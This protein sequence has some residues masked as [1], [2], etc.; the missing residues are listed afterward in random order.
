MIF[1]Y[2]YHPLGYYN[3]VMI[4]SGKLKGMFRRLGFPMFLR[5]LGLVLFFLF[6][7]INSVPA[8][9]FNLTYDYSVTSLPNATA[10][11]NAVDF[12]AA[13][14]EDVFTDDVTI[15]VT[16][17]AVSGTSI[18][19]HS[20][21]GVSGPFTY[22]QIRNA[23]SSKSTT[24]D[25]RSAL[26]YLPYSDPSSGGVFY[27]TRAQAKALGLLSPSTYSDGTFSFGAGQSF[28]LDTTYRAMSGRGDFVGIAQHE[29][30]EIM[31][32]TMGA[33]LGYSNPGYTVFDLFRFT[34]SGLRS[35]YPASGAY[36]SIDGGYNQ[37]K[38]FNFPNGNGSDPGDW[39]PGSNDACNNYAYFGVVNEF[40]DLDIR[41]MDVL[42]YKPFELT[43][44][45]IIFPAVASVK[46]GQSVTLS[47]TA[48]SGLPVSYSVYSGTGA[49]IYGNR[50][51]FT[52]AGTV[53]IAAN[54]GGNADFAAAWPV[55][56]TVVVKK[57][58]QS[59]APFS[60]IPE[61]TYGVAPFGITFPK[62][63]SGLAVKV[64]V[65]SGPATISGK[66]LTITGAGVVTMA[67]NQAGN[68]NYTAAK[69]ITT[70]FAVAKTSQTLTFRAI[71][72]QKIGAVFTL[73]ATASSGLVVTY[74]VSGP[75]KISG[76]RLT[77]TGAGKVAVGA[78]QT[79]NASYAPAPLA[80]VSFTA[81]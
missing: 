78:H 46:V 49:S 32:R 18:Y 19:G 47:A 14:L 48:T 55:L 2:I 25:D 16:V 62:A 36:F 26:S 74:S 61:K 6:S 66:T 28:N 65:K 70:S 33:N 29:L 69:E 76:N 38:T 34:N 21:Y 73:R 68:A 43:A 17:Y 58:S 80:R 42:G 64:T 79:G 37:L 60:I 71:A 23:L 30:S 22:G 59:I 40:S 5:S 3:R 24:A 11:M 67:A 53:Q 77:V 9:T 39:A 4:F 81:N 72:N 8:L 27:L 15:N 10:Y 1:F 51:T 57:G 45:G 50:V 63:T 31:G 20:T 35:F 13:E 44:Q 12:A 75:A 41:V 7:P 52:T 56:Q 54:Q